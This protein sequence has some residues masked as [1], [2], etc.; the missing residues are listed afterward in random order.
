VQDGAPGVQHGGVRRDLVVVLG[1][2]TGAEQA[3]GEATYRAG[4]TA[5]ADRAE[6]H[7]SG[8]VGGDYRPG[9]GGERAYLLLTRD[10]QAGDDDGPGGNGV[11]DG[12]RVVHVPSVNGQVR[13]GG[14]GRVAG[15]ADHGA[16][17]MASFEG[18]GDEVAAGAAGGA[19]DGDPHQFT[20]PRA[21]IIAA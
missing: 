5:G 10:A 16:D 2:E 6:P 4:R 15:V 9:A 21:L 19:E 11:G 12:S 14:Q 8:R 3:G 17:L 18:L 20:S 1:A 7:D 13:M